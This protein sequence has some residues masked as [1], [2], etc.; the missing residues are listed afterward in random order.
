MEY[1]TI[2]QKAE[3][4]G[5]SEK[6]VQVLCREGRIRGAMRFGRVWAIPAEASKPKDKRVRTGK[7]VNW[8]LKTDEQAYLQAAGGQQ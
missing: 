7:Y 5:I 1:K 4:W 6:R 2:S 8:R 3:E